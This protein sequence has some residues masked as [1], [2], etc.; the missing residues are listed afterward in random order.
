MTDSPPPRPSAA[1]WSDALLTSG[2]EALLGAVRN[3]IGPVKTPYDKRDLVSKLEAFLRRAETRDSLLALLD[4]LDLKII[5]SSLLMG[6]V[7]EQA[8]KELFVGELPLFELGV[9]ISNLLDRLLL[10]RYQ[11]G[12]RRLVAVNPL[13]EEE[14]RAIALDPVSLF[15]AAK[16][17]P[18]SPGAAADAKAAIA[19]FSFLF[20]SPTSTRKS[21]GLTKRAAERAA[22]L[23]PELAAAGG[24][25]LGTLARALTVS[26]ALASGADDERV[27]DR[28]AFARMLGEWGGRLPFYLAACLAVGP[29]Q[30]AEEARADEG[31]ARILANVASGAFEALPRGLSLS[32]PGLARW[33]RIAA[34]RARLEADP[35]LVLPCLESLGLL[36]ESEGGVALAA[37]AAEDSPAERDGPSLVVEGAHALHLMPEAS[38]EDRLFVGLAARPSSIGTAWSFDVERDT[39]RRAFAAGLGAAGI[40]ERFEAM[41][42]MPLPQSFAFSLA[43]WEEEFRSLRLYRGFVLAAD[44]RQRPVIERSAALGRIV[45]E[46]LAPG[47][48]F[49]SASTA[50][51]AAAALAAAGLDPP[52]IAQAAGAGEGSA[53]GDAPRGGEGPE[54]RARIAALSDAIEAGSAGR[55]GPRLDPEARLAEL[56]ACLASSGRPEEQRRELADR[57][58]RRLVLTERQIAQSDPHPERLEAGGL[59]YLGKVRVVERALRSSGDR[60]EVLYRLPGAEPVRALLRPVRLEKNDKGLVLE[61]E[62]LGT[63]GPARV[64]LGSVSTVRRLRASLFGEEQ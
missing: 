43:A 55:P 9:R 27:P 14:L 29:D 54:A 15:E 4:R 12:G 19:L 64:P 62:D 46:K 61:A 23:F 11:V 7:P 8:L 39:V 28:E 24:D 59:D 21:G 32:R 30:A 20:H 63:G 51:E 37:P 10:F 1:D 40:R 44:E 56:R 52:P 50:E 26:G 18:A 31:K 41:S 48:Y 5:G 38:L 3:Y 34:S 17:I 2:S 57:I 16:P 25:R 45:A 22:S 58:E 53:R 13:L 60:L 33:L 42:G 35:A 6:P 36:A 47:V 49:L